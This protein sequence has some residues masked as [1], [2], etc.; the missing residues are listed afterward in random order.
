MRHS[1]GIATI[2]WRFFARGLAI[3]V[4]KAISAAIFFES[5]GF[6][7]VV[8]QMP[9]HCKDVLVAAPAHIH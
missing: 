9:R 6:G 1:A 5:I 4:L 2:V 3:P 8:V 7:N